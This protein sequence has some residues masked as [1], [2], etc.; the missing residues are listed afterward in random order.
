MPQREEVS[1]MANPTTISCTK[2]VWTKVATAVTY[3]QVWVLNNLP[4]YIHT[5][6]LTGE[7]APNDTTDRPKGAILE[8]SANIGS[9]VAIDV[10]VMA[11]NEDGLVRVDL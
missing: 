4:H 1:L 10:Y 8:H 6:K 7:P 3:G 11:L 2:D 9:T 5:Y